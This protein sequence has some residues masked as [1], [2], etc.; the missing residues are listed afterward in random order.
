MKMF[1]ARAK[2]EELAGG[3]YRNLTYSVTDNHV[4]E[5]SFECTVYIDGEGH[6]HGETW[7]ESLQKMEFSIYPERKPVTD[8]EDV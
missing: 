8:V 5:V 4:G 3:K 1:E 7:E 6:H 2:L